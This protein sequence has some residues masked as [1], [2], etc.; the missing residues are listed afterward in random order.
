MITLRRIIYVPSR[1]SRV[2]LFPFTDTHIGARAF[3]EKLHRQHIARVAEDEFA[4][5]LHLGDATDTI[6]RKGD[7]RYQESTTAEWLRGED[8]VI[9]VQAD[10]AVNLYRSIAHKCIAWGKGNHEEGALRYAGHDVYRYLVKEIARAASVEPES[11][12]YGVQGFV[13]LEFRRGTPQAYR[14]PWRLNLYLFHGTGGGALP[15]GH[16]LALGRVLGNFDCDIALMGH[17][18]VRQFVDKVI[19]GPARHGGTT[20]RYRAAMFVPSYLDAWVK[21]ATRKLPV[22]TYIDHVGL[23]PLPL[24]TTP[25]VVWPEER[26][27][28]CVI[29]AGRTVQELVSRTVLNTAGLESE[30][31]PA[32]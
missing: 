22:D 26:T 1:A 4:Y 5:W 29:G 31:E 27:F 10:Y 19:T 15:G 8:D 23:P 25:I 21:P 14:D 24:G 7:K 6:A 2:T 30:A 18:H 20:Q 28:D 32:V 16:A 12:A 9:T 17:R 11:I 3:D 13:S